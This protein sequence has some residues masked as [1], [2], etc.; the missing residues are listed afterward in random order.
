MSVVAQTFLFALLLALGDGNF[1]FEKCNII[2]FQ[3]SQAYNLTIDSNLVKPM[4]Q[5]K[6]HSPRDGAM[7]EY[8]IQSMKNNFL[9]D[10]CCII[11]VTQ[12]F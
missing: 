11:F 7:H 5:L 2:H 10:V 1:I 3:T 9:Y 6:H 12:H 4:V 8:P